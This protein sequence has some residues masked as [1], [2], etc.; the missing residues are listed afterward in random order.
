MSKIALCFLVTKN[1]INLDV[2]KK[3]WKGHE[4][5]INIYAHFSKKGSITQ[6]ELLKNRVKAV[7][8]RWGDIS[9]VN[10][11]RE[12]Y[13]KAYKN[14]QNAQFILISDSCVPIRTFDVVYKRLMKDKKRGILPYRS[15]G[16]YYKDDLV[17]F[18]D[19]D[20]CIKLME[21]FNFFTETSYA[22]DQWKSLSRQNVHDFLKMYKNKSY[23]KLFSR[24]CT[25]IIPDSLAPDE[26][27][28]I[29]WLR[30]MYGSKNLKKHV[31]NGLVT[32]V[33][34]KGKAIHPITYRQITDNLKRELCYSDGLFA[35]K[36]V[37]PLEKK[38]LSQVPVKC[39]RKR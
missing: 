31:R 10:A 23:V 2:W 19:K 20:K 9:L 24:F 39:S 30:Y 3:W 17:P 36:F 12:L 21:K 33:D 5:K 37:N 38:L 29:N 15:L 35:R 28:Y 13:K 11:E 1:I 32:Y 25:D 18:K 14:K 26:L 8:T 16:K 7:P 34:F 6:P 27:M 22:C 4:D